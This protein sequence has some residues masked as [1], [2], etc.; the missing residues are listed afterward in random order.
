M[1][2]WFSPY[3]LVPRA[4]LNARSGSRPRNGALLRI[5]SGFADLHPWPELGDLPLEAHLASIAAGRPTSLARRSLD[6]AAAD[7][8][9]RELGVSLF[10]G[11]PIPP[12]HYPAGAGELPDF[13][14]LER[15]GFDR[16]KMK[17]GADAGADLARL[18]AAAPSLLGTPIRLRIDFNSSLTL[19]ELGEML[20]A[21]TP[22]LLARIDFLEDPVP[23]EAA[24]W[25]EIRR[26]WGVR[27]AADREKLDPSSWDIAVIK[28]A[29]EPAG[30]AASALEMGKPLV[31]T[32]AM[33]HPIGQLWAAWNAAVA[34]KDHPGRVLA[35]GLLSHGVYEANEFSD[36]LE[37]E[38]AVL[39]PPDRTGLGF[40]DL[41]EALEWKRLT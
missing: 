20:A 17:A 18:T 28:P 29:W 14:F 10:E 38:G 32:S 16:V 25:N 12:S 19:A 24:T 33:D 1:T 36:R 6:C 5:G 41:L 39:L 35:C 11:L 37:A 15:A 31:F 23:P 26:R 9:A 40:D 13:R 27:L 21:M 22:Q 8:Q 34:Q 4:E 30:A 7:G 3:T 2:A